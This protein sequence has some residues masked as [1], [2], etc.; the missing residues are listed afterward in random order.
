LLGAAALA[1]G[2]T[3]W[4]LRVDTVT[5]ASV[6]AGNF[7]TILAEQTDLSIESIDLMLSE[8]DRR[9]ENLGANRPEAF[10]TFTR[11]K[12]YY[13]LLVVRMCH[14]SHVTVIALADNEGRLL[15]TTSRWPLLGVSI[16]DRKYFQY[17]RSH[18]DSSIY[19]SDPA[20]SRVQ[21]AETIF[22]SRRLNGNNNKFLGIIVIGIK[23]EYFRTSASPTRSWKTAKCW[24]RTAIWSPPASP[25]RAS[26]CAVADQVPT[27]PVFARDGG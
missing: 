6:N 22:F 3:L 24:C 21:G 18:D 16:A 27:A 1:I 14:L 8:I 17:A 26:H 2:L 20:I 12:D 13:E 23:L 19:I 15:V 11:H 10:A 4:W 25:I 7:A 5:N 9:L